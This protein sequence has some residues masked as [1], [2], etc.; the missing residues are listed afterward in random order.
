MGWAECT[1]LSPC[2]QSK[3]K[4]T[5]ASRKR[6]LRRAVAA[7]IENL[8]SRSSIAFIVA[9]INNGNG[10]SSVDQYAGT[11][12]SGWDSSWQVRNSNST[13]T[14]ATVD[15]TNPLNGGGNYLSATLTATAGS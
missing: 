12:G 2:G 15:N 11:S 4:T 3:M 14:T 6:V 1:P 8:A 9:A 5:V 7:V 13:F 10:T